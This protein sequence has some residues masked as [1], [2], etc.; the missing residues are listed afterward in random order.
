LWY[1]GRADEAL[2]HLAQVVRLVPERPVSIERAEALAAYGRLLML[3]GVFRRAV[4]PLEEAL[5]LGGR[6]GA[7]AV[8]ASALDTLAIVYSQLGDNERAIASGL[9]GL[10]IAV[11]LGDGAEVARGYINSTQAI[12]NAGRLEEALA[13]GLE[14]IAVAHRMGVDR[15]AGDQLRWQAA[16]RLIRLG[17]FAAAEQLV[18]DTLARASLTFNRAAGMNLAGYL[19]AVRGDFDRAEELLG[20]AWELMQH[21]GGFQLLGLA[22]AWRISLSLWRGQIERAGQLVAEAMERLDVGEGQLIYTAEVYWLAGRV[23]ADRAEAARIRS[24]EAEATQA[25]AAAEV[26][27]ARLAQAT[28]TYL[29]GGAPPEALAFE[30]LLHGELDRARGNTDVQPW[31]MAAQ[32]FNALGQPLRAAYADMRAAEALALAG[33]PARHVAEPLRRAHTA[34]VERGM[35]PFRE[36][37]EALARR[38]GLALSGD[39]ADAGE[40][41]ELGLTRRELEVLALLAEGQTNR[42]IARELFITEKTASAHVSHIL[43][44]LGVANR[45]AAGTAAYRLGL[46]RPSTG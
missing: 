16:W 27:A 28:A 11:E 35:V 24:L 9:E 23:H 38:T 2:E 37:V 43:M 33:A 42:E 32:R 17:R 31:L 20:R 15:A 21:S 10:R 18:S 34:A 22:L 30:T 40:A 1:G 8:E 12:D 26:V 25:T 5:E 6:L 36:E 14:G 7:R 13:Q 3:N 39:R 46:C 19:A 4:G 44:K 41:E 45:A 29:V